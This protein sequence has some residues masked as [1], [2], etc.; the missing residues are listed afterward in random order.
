MS[1]IEIA[2]TILEETGVPKMYINELMALT[3]LTLLGL[4]D[5]DKWSNASISGLYRIHDVLKNIRETFGKN[6]A[7]NSR[8]TL[9]KRVM[10]V[11]EQSIIIVRNIDD[12]TRPTTSGKTNYSITEEYLKVIKAYGTDDYEIFLEEFLSIHG[13]LAEQYAKKRDMHKVPLEIN[14]ETH[15]LSA[16]THNELQVAIIEEFASRF[17]HGSELLY[18]GDTANKYIFVKKEILEEIGIPISTD[19]KLQL[20]DVVLYDKT[21]NW[22][23]LIEAVTT[24]GPIDQK[25]INDLET[26]FANCPAEKVYVTAFPDRKTFRQYIAEIAWETEVWISSDPDHMVHFNGDKFMGPYKPEK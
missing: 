1:N 14:G 24:H 3:F 20:P 2:K 17:A 23:Y 7:E 15:L 25:R 19:D 21:K 8:E 18:I 10:R 4:N 5:T 6:Y 16:G 13:D 26:M 9:R 22:I 11:L 12:F